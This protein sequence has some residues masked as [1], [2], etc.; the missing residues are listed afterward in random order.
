MAENGKDVRDSTDGPRTTDEGEI[1]EDGGRVF[2]STAARRD[3]AL[4]IVAVV[5]LL[6]G[7]P[8][9]S[10]SSRRV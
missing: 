8:S 10:N 3:A 5:T 9:R 1:E 6:L 2:V 7:L 4:R